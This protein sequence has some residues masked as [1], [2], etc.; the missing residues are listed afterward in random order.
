MTGSDFFHI[1]EMITKKI[2]LEMHTNTYICILTSVFG[3]Q[4]TNIEPILNGHPI[5]FN[6]NLVNGQVIIHSKYTPYTKPSTTVM[7]QC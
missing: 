4:P 1:T 7:I 3:V 5:I 6:N 2:D